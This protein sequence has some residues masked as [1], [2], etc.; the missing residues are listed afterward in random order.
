MNFRDKNIRFAQRYGIPPET[1]SKIKLVV[2]LPK[3]AAR[4][5]NNVAAFILA[6]NVLART[7]KQIYVVF[8]KETRLNQ[9]P[10]G[11]TTIHKLVQDINQTSNNAIKV[12]L[13][14][15]PDIV[16]SI[17]C[18]TSLKARRTTFTSGSQWCAALD[19]PF[20][21]ENSGP[22]G[23]LYAATMGSAQV[24]LHALD[25]IGAEYKP[26]PPF[27]FNLLDYSLDNQNEPTMQSITIPETH[28]VGIGAV[29]SSCLYAL[30]HL[31]NISGRIHL[32]DNEEVDEGNLNRYILMRQSD[33]GRP[34]VEIGADAFYAKGL[35]IVSHN[36]TY[37]Q[38][39][40]K[41]GGEVNLL[42]T[43][44]DSEETRCAITKELPR[45][46]I[47]VA[48]G[49]TTVTLSTHGFADGKACMHCLYMPK[50]A[51]KS[52]PEIIAEDTGLLVKQVEDLITSNIPLDAQTV[53]TIAS[54]RKVPTDTWKEHIGKTILSFYEIAVCG[55]AGL[56]LPTDNITAPLAFISCAG[57][58][59]L[60]AE[61]VKLGDTELR[62]YALDNYLRI[63]TIHKPNLAFKHTKYQDRSGLCICHDLD[64]VSVY[65]SKYT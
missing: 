33:V 44:V 7:F 20:E 9:H 16:F 35:D 24:L 52:R 22:L 50:T 15:N 41:Y 49:G 2:E 14:P 58:I 13:P 43:P 27:L 21:S 61:L 23:S 3:T 30:G 1:F 45:H 26:M 55:D 12:C 18:P 48:T 56:R 60:A 65:R 6:V 4:L 34:K 57:G 5:D 37:G 40:K 17:G 39:V 29:G 11:L 31:S 10:W 38:Y 59:L 63:D 54:H 32:I 51:A 28:L 53:A 42:L 25:L 62:R 47:N 19:H 64:Y 46:I 8:P 36:M